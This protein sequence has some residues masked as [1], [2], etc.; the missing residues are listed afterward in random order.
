[1]GSIKDLEKRLIEFSN[2]FDSV[3][4]IYTGRGMDEDNPEDEAVNNYYLLTNSDF[5]FKM[6][7]AIGDFMLSVRESHREFFVYQFSVS[8]DNIEQFDFLET[9]I[10]RKQ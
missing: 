6:D 7:D 9:C 4:A 10:Y 8:P 2:R 1:M 5:D 3:Y